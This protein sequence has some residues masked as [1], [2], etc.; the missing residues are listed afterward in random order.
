MIC[1]V[2]KMLFI[3][4]IPQ[5]IN[6]HFNDKIF[7]VCTVVNTFQLGREAEISL[8][9]IWQFNVKS[10]NFGRTISIQPFFYF[11]SKISWQ[12]FLNTVDSL[13]I[14]KYA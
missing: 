11:F 13:Y 6:W 4:F 10:L 2:K 5:I 7:F 9:I 8:H 3:W 14:R 1:A 12:A